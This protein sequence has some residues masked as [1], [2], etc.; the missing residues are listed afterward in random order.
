MNIQIIVATHKD[1]WMPADDLYLPVQVGS[2]GKPTLRDGWQR[3]DAGENIS[4]KNPHY[5]ELTG[6]YW[7]WKHLNADYIGLVHYRRYFAGRCF[8][9]KKRRI[10]TRAQIEGKLQKADAL[11]PRKRRYYIET[12]YGQYVHA[13]HEADLV[14]TKEILRETCPEYLPCWETAMGRTYGH[15]F[16]M[17]VMKRD[18]FDAYCAWLFDVLFELEKRL[19]ISGYSQN[20]ARVFGFVSERLLDI[21]LMKNEIAAVELPTVNLENQHWPKKIAAFLKRKALGGRGRK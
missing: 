18:V 6:L 21:W 17:F 8:G 20:D 7:A 5:C 3:D 13:H 11:L 16:N 19:D 12:N 2:A 14:T 10:A 9:E 4:G 1:Y 15:R